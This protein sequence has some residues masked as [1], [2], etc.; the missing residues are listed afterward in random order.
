MEGDDVE[1]RIARLVVAVETRTGQSRLVRDV[2][3]EST[4]VAIRPS[5]CVQLT[6]PLSSPRGILGA[7]VLESD[8]PTAFDD[9]DLALVTLF[10]QQATIVLERAVLHEQLMRQSRL[11]RDMDIARDILKSLDPESAPMFT[12]MDV[13]GQSETAGGE[14]RLT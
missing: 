4:Y 8:R 7:I 12:G 5:T 2:R 3:R 10:G 13:F 14:V 1:K 6:V 11:D 9:Q